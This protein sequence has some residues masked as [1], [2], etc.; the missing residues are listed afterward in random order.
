MR[1]MQEPI[2]IVHSKNGYFIGLYRNT[3]VNTG[4]I[5]IYLFE[6]IHIGKS[7]RQIYMRHTQAQEHEQ[8]NLEGTYSR[9]IKYSVKLD[10]D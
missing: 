5:F 4:T 6:N 1:K 9:I 10:E 7:V 8:I 2:T 3:E